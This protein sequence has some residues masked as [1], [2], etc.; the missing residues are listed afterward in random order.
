M[1]SLIVVFLTIAFLSAL[2][3]VAINYTPWWIERAQTAQELTR[4][5]VA[6]LERAYESAAAAGTPVDTPPVP[7]ADA[8]GGLQALLKPYAGFTPKAPRNMTWTY[9]HQ[10]AAG[11]FEGMD[12]ICL[13]GSSVELGEYQAIQLLANTWGSTQAVVSNVCGAAASSSAPSSLPAP[14]A[15]T[16]YLQYVPGAN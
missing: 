7:T 11:A 13:Q 3:V 8:D 12:Y 1:F 10:G 14:V 15:L 5:G 16:Y 6:T 2:A 4:E 9:G